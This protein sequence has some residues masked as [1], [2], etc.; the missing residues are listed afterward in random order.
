MAYVEQSRR[1]GIFIHRTEVGHT[2]NRVGHRWSTP[3]T[4][5]EHK[6]RLVNRWDA[7]RAEVHEW[8]RTCTEWERC[9]T[10]RTEQN[11]DTT[12]TKLGGL[13]HLEQSRRWAYRQ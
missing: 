7:P 5:V 9:G 11:V 4:V 8:K 13:I 3:G 1:G 2:S 10:P 12:T 6:K